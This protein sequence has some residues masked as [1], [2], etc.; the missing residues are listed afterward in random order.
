ML[1]ALGFG[2]LALA[3]SA[4]G[5]MAENMCGD[6]PIAPAIPSVADMNQKTPADA[7]SARHSAFLDVVRWQNSLKSYRQCL[8][9][10]V[11][12]DKRQL[13]EA[14]RSDKPD[15]DKITRIGDEITAMG[16]LYDA[17]VDDEE[18]VVND[19]HAAL[20]AYC[21]RSDVDKSACPKTK[22]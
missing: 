17:S 12:T 13:G 16:H 19:F 2:L 20:T 21:N 15:K 5:A 22:A 8:D 10:S 9:A 14:Q 18:R 1:R 6:E 7:A 3:A 11:N 4:G